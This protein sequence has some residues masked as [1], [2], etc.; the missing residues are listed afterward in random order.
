MT[1]VAK[2]TPA[3]DAFGNLINSTGSTPNVYLFAG[4]QFDPA[5]GLYYNRARYLNTTTGRFWSMDTDE[6][7]DGDPLSLHKY[8]Y[9]ADSPV[10]HI[11]PAGHEEVSLGATMFAMSIAVTITAIGG[12]TFGYY[13][14]KSNV[15]L[16]GLAAQESAKPMVAAALENLQG[17]NHIQIF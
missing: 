9:V 14:D 8:L 13:L 6:G 1:L 10:D 15:G 16:E 5:L 4:E 2:P 7:R 3:N 11:D 17:G 12:L